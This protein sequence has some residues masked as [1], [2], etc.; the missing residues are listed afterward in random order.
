[1][2]NKK[3]IVNFYA[4]GGQDENG[5]NCF[6]LEI[7]NK[8]F[9]V[10]AGGKIPINSNYGIDTI[11]PNF[12]F[13]QLNKHKIAGVFISDIKN[14][15]FSALP[16]LVNM[17]NNLKIYTSNINKFFVI[18]RLSKYKIKNKYEIISVHET[19][20]IFDVEV[21]MF[22]VAGSLPEQRGMA[23]RYNGQVYLFLMNLVIGN[24]GNY[25]F[26]DLNKIKKITGNSKITAL[27]LDSGKA[28]LPGKSIENVSLKNKIQNFFDKSKF[29]QKIFIAGFDE[30]IAT[31]EEVLKICFQ[32]KRPVAVYGKKYNLFLYLTRKSHKDKNF[33]QIINFTEIKK[34]RNCV[35]LITGTV[36]K[37]YEIFE[38][39]IQKKDKFI[40]INKV[41]RVL[42]IAPP[43]NGL[44][45]KYANLLSDIAKVVPSVEDVLE[46]DFYPFR[47]AKQDVYDVVKFFQPKYFF[48]IQG[49]YRYLKEARKIAIETGLVASNV[50]I[51]KNGQVLTFKNGELEKQKKSFIRDSGEKV[52]DGTGICELNSEIIREREALL[53]NGFFSVSMLLCYKTKNFLSDFKFNS[54]GFDKNLEVKKE[55]EKFSKEIIIRYHESEKHKISH[56]DYQEKIRKAIRRKI[57]KITEKEPIISLI[58]YEI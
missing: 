20:K 34:Y 48:P 17:I 19:L 24:L 45:V 25:G 11:I 33:P 18:E 39:V 3:K 29:D 49:L 13:L 36:E 10:N 58:F 6:C 12:N 55:I 14:E 7:N 42:F 41:D 31:L 21:S 51:S 54:Y 47:P 9:V 23:F 32:K 46:T 44:E 38:K 15:S 57:F 53:K 16:W 37:L 43:V 52:I 30:E 28:N 1:M 22:S 4:L 5:K 27:F 56:K 50:I 2:L 26:T 35:V 8:I 40:Q